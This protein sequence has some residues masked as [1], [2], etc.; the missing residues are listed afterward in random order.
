MG[1]LLRAP[2]QPGWHG[3]RCMITGR[4]A[5]ARVAGLG[6]TCCD[7]ERRDRRRH[8]RGGGQT[9][10]P[11]RRCRACCGDRAVMG[12]SAGQ[13]RHGHGGVRDDP[14]VAGRNGRGHGRHG[15]DGARGLDAR[16]CSR[17][18]PAVGVRSDRY[19]F[20]EDSPY[21]TVDE[22]S[23]PTDAGGN[24]LVPESG[25]F[26]PAEPMPEKKTRRSRVEASA[27]WVWALLGV[28]PAPCSTRHRTR[29]GW[30]RRRP[31]R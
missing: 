30:C 1:A 29:Q 11:R 5:P 27:R 7:R 10:S 15:D 9:R 13:R 19:P 31:H 24:Y 20:T 21:S 23:P 2:L 26:G 8:T 28:G 4:P 16:L 17:G 22:I 18:V 14:H 3:P 6:T 12:V 25:A